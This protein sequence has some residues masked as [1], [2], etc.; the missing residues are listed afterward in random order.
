MAMRIVFMGTPEFAVPALEGLLSSNH[1]LVAVYTQPDKPVGRGRK[2]I[3][4]PAKQLAQEH[5]MAVVQPVTLRDRAETDRLI[6]LSPDVIVVVAYGQMLPQEVLDI[7]QFGCLN[8]HPSLLPK[9]RGASPIPSAILEGETETGVSIMLMDAGMDSGPVINLE[10]VP[11]SLQD[12]AAT[13]SKKLTEI[14]SELLLRT[15]PLWAEGRLTPEP[16]DHAKATY[17]RPI[18][19]RDGEIDWHLSAA[20]LDRRVRAFDPWP[21]CFTRWQGKT[22]KILEAVALPAHGPIKP[23]LVIS[24]SGDP[25][26]PVGVGTSNGILG[27][28]R[29][30]LE[31]KRP[32]SAA[33]FLRGHRLEAGH[34]LKS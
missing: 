32:V 5:G 18:S 14:G 34:D 8:I 28:R 20:E 4:P 2:W 12:T 29:L 22:L 21:G 19:K 30:Q 9:Y 13:L 7:P 15:L 25:N 33:D 1:E 3:P 23:G 17:T 26:I 31:G 24:L 16:Q 6:G 10:K 27:L 11:V